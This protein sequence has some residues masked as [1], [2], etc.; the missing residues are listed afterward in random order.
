MPVKH[1]LNILISKYS[2]VFK[3]IVYYAILLLLLVSIAAGIVA[4]IF[5]EMSAE[6]QSTGVGSQVH[7][8][9]N[10][11]IHGDSS[12]IETFQA[13]GVTVGT[14][15]DIVKHNNTAVINGL[16]VIAVFA[17]LYIYLISFA[18]LVC[19]DV[20]NNFM[21]SNSRFGFISNFIYNLGR[22]AL[23]GLLYMITYLP[24]T[25][26][27]LVAT[28]FIG[29]GLV[30]GGAILLAFPIAV[31]FFL[32]W[33]SLVLTVFAGWLPAI[34]VDKKNVAKALVTGPQKLFKNFGYCWMSVF[35]TMFLCFIF[36]SASTVF[37]FGIGFVIAFPTAVVAVKILELVL[38]YN[39][40]GYKFYET[41]KMVTEETMPNIEEQ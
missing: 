27:G 19:S 24:A 7:L 30:K 40:N 33:Q 23:Y 8:F 1:S 25:I 2:V 5:A 6:I 13:I 35:V 36:V 16:V 28:Y 9:F 41:D 11:F 15:I 22:S 21:N 29:Y 38:Y 17:I 26:I 20:I 12:I 34:V 10:E 18:N 3:M 4:P 39:A 37:T 31:L 14:I 32:V